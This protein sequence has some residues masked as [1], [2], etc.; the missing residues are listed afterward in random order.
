MKIVI[1]VLTGIIVVFGTLVL[2]VLGSG[3]GWAVDNMAGS[4]DWVKQ[5]A[6]WPMPAWLSPWFD[7]A[8][9]ESIRAAMTAALEAFATGLPWLAPMLG[10]LVPLMWVLWALVVV[11]LLAVALGLSYLLGRGRK[12]ANV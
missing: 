1:W 12:L 6:Q 3:I 5:I 4:A 8:A 7:A 2:L 9:L 11:C 10:W